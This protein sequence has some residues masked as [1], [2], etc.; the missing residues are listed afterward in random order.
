MPFQL[1]QYFF[2]LFSTN[3]KF[4]RKKQLK[5]INFREALSI[6]KFREKQCPQNLAPLRQSVQFCHRN[7]WCIGISCRV[8]GAAITKHEEDQFE[9]IP[10][11]HEGVV[12]ISLGQVR[13][14]KSRS[15]PVACG[16]SKLTKS[17]S[18]TRPS[19]VAKHLQLE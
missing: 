1:E 19:A 9:S 15:R 4:L 18:V 17:L 10:H 11:R 13:G 12:C 14:G 7:S 6:A 3:T 5:R 2:V 8:L 16:S